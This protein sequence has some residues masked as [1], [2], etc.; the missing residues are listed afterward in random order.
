MRWRNP[1]ARLTPDESTLTL[2]LALTLILTLIL[3]LTLT[4]T[5]TLRRWRSTRAR[6]LSRLAHPAG[7]ER[8]PSRP[9]HRL[10]RS[11]CSK[12]RGR[13]TH[14]PAGMISRRAGPPSP[15]SPCRSVP[16]PSACS[17]ECS[18]RPPRADGQCRCR[19]LRYRRPHRCARRLRRRLSPRRRAHSRPRRHPRRSDR[20]SSA[21][22]ALSGR[23]VRQWLLSTRII[24]GIA[25]GRSDVGTMKLLFFV[26]KFL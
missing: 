6:S 20:R 3:T 13:A 23:G 11:C 14:V 19:W 22:R 4:L 16:R 17:P 26:S 25:I 5:L 24:K 12:G 9:R 8:G 7:R 1:A 10:R 2:T 21:C 15:R 18:P